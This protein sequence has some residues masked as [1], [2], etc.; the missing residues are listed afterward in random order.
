L[1]VAKRE[2]RFDH[3]I[4]LSRKTTEII[5]KSIVCIPVVE[6]LPRLEVKAERGF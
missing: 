4:V 2:E 3:K 6:H 5:T 1:Q